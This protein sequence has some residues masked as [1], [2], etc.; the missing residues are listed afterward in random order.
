MNEVAIPWYTFDWFVP[1]TLKAFSWEWPVFIYLIPIILL[2]FFIRWFLR[3][4]FSQKL[5]VAVTQKE[6]KTSPTNLI[7]LLPEF[8]L[9]LTLILLLVSMARPQ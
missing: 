5:P 8:F 7:R 3:H 1:S 2:L 9:M 6:L 4:R